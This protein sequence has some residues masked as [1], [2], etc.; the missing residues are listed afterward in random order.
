MSI[1]GKIINHEN[2]EL[3]KFKK[4]ADEIIAIEDTVA[5][6]S[7]DKLKAKTEYFQKRINKGEDLEDILVEAFAVA[8]EAAY[9]VIGEKPFYVQ[10][11]GGLAIHYGNIAEMKTGEGKTLTSVLPAYLNALSGNGVHIITVNEYL[12]NRD[13]NWMGKIFEFLGLKVGVNNKD[14]SADQKREQYNCDIMYST[15]NEIGFDYL[16]DNM[17]VRKE[18]RV[19][20]RG[21]NFA[22]VDE[23]DSV[24]VDEARTPLIISGGLLN[25]KDLYHNADRFAKNLKYETDYTVDEQTETIALTDDGVKKAEKMFNLKN[26][27]DL[28]NT[29]LVHH[30]SQALRANFVF[31]KDVH[32]VITKEDGIVIVDK[33]TGRLMKGRV[34]GEGLH[35]AIEAKEGVEIQAET[36]TIATITFQNL[37]RM[38]NKLSGMTGTAKTEEEEFR[39]IY[40][41]YVITIPT[42]KPVIREDFDD[43]IFI[44][45]R[46]KYKAIIKEIVNRHK[47]GQPI[48]VGT[49]SIEVS[50]IISEMLTKEKITHEVLNAKNHEREAHI[51]EQAGVKGAVTIATNMA[52]RGTDIKINDEVKALGGLAVI[53][54]E[55][56]ESRRI[57]NQL[58]GRSGRQGDPGFSQFCISLEDEL[59]VRFGSERMKMFL[60]RLNADEEMS[61]RI[62]IFSKSV[63][64]AQRRVEGNNFDAR[65]N[66]LQFD[67]VVGKQRETIYQKRNQIL[68][69][70]DMHQIAVEY[71]ENY[72]YSL[73]MDHAGNNEKL[74]DHEASELLERINTE[75]ININVKTEQ[76]INQPIDDVISIIT[77]K[78]VKLYKD[79]VSQVQTEIISEFEKAIS[80][81]VI[82]SLWVDHLTTMEQ[83]SEGMNLRSISQGNPIQA[84]TIEGYQMFEKL[85]DNI[86]K[87]ITLYLLKAEVMQNFE[88]KQVEK[89][90]GTNRSD[91]TA[92]KQPKTVNK[93]GRNNP[94]PCGSGKKYK[95]C[96]G[97]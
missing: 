27:Y 31:K 5:K 58:R 23:V 87:D 52:G 62:K 3:K 28:D 19:N 76:I 89:P 46:G 15:D 11:L 94:C 67:D 79:K 56:H 86:E 71:I 54:T 69:T 20:S 25:A 24:L 32:Y 95:Q 39:D 92:K 2:K 88:R 53:G 29:A 4:I 17:V 13:A 72:L 66:L 22:I 14:Y 77:K 47:T 48:L 30:I 12:A 60:D 43:L 36:R 50:E 8:R 68:G 9:R 40:N 42:N 82:D 75:I 93:V 51:I 45:Q 64:Q 74:N 26:L 6:L 91:E 81:R 63:E 44:N 1:L 21:L 73:V 16:R 61:I 7:D 90:V 80:L 34:Y 78:I 35:Q 65:K 97:K 37:F 83:L 59:L 84:Y 96:C 41:M 10:L 57:D 18:D 70:E 38:Y 85:L 33:F 49:A 55:R